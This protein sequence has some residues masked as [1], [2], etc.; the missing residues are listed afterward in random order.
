MGLLGFDKSWN[1]T[2]ETSPASLGL[3]IAQTVIERSMN[4]G[5]NEANNYTA[6]PA[7]EIRN[8]PLWI[9]REG[10]P[11]RYFPYPNQFALFSHPLFLPS[12]AYCRLSSW[13]PLTSGQFPDQIAVEASPY[14][15]FVTPHWGRV[16]PFAMTAFQ[17]SDTKPGVWL[18][19]GEPPRLGEYPYS[20]PP[21]AD[22]LYFTANQTNLV[23]LSGHLDPTDGEMWNISPG[24]RGNNILGVN[25]GGGWSKNPATGQPYIA[26]Q[27]PRGDYTRVIAE[28]CTFPQQLI[29]YFFMNNMTPFGKPLNFWFD[30]L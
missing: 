23:I 27:V 16:V 26:Q 20:Y 17:R 30:S 24:G 14:P 28:Y 29:L 12:N 18:D 13:Q 19:P 2:K 1:D 3:R 22:D 8:K 15:L 4:D 21:S 9:Q 25:T 7:Y 10:N 5:S 6:N 11:V